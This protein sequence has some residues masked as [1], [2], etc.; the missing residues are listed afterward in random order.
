MSARPALSPAP[1]WG[2]DADPSRS[3]SSPIDW[4]W[5]LDP[6]QPFEALLEIGGALVRAPQRPVEEVETGGRILNLYL[7]VCALS[8]L[9]GEQLHEGFLDLT[10]IGFGGTTR[11]ILEAASRA[12]WAV[13]GRATSLR[14]WNLRRREWEL[15]ALSRT[16]AGAV[17]AGRRE[18]DAETAAA[19]ARLRAHRWTSSLRRRRLTIPARLRDLDLYPAD[20]ELLA[21]R[22]IEAG[23]SSDAPVLVAGLETAGT[24]YVAP[25]FAAALERLGYSH[26]EPLGLRP[27]C[28]L[29][30]ADARRLRR[31]AAAGCWVLVIDDPWQ[32][33]TF[34]RATTALSEVGVH[35]GRICLVEFRLPSGPCA[36]DVPQLPATEASVA[37]PGLDRARRA[38]LS[39]EEWHIHRLLDNDAVEHWLNRPAVLDRTGAEAAVVLASHRFRVDGQVPGA[40]GAPEAQRPSSRRSRVHKLFE[41]EL[42]RQGERWREL[43]LGRGVGLGFFG[44]HSRLIAACLGDRVP[45]VLGIDQGILFTRWEPGRGAPDPLEPEELDEIAAYVAARERRLGLGTTRGRPLADSPAIG[46]KH[47]GRLLSCSMGG[48]ARPVRQRVAQALSRA[49]APPRQCLA[50]GQMGPANWVRLEHGGLLKVGFQEHG[51]HS[52]EGYVADP[53]YD[54]AGASIGFRLEPE[55]ERRLLDRYVRLTGDDQDLPARLS[56]HKLLNALVDLEEIARLGLELRT[57]AGRSAYARELAIRETLVT[58]T[59]NEYLASLYLQDASTPYDGPPWVL[60]LEGV[61]ETDRLGFA[62]TSPAGVLALRALH[63]HGQQV[64]LTSG[65]SLG[66]VRERCRTYRLA[67]GIAED[68]A[69][70]WD[71]RR[72]QVLTLLPP[73]ARRDLARLR[74]ALS[75][76]TDSMTDPRYEHSIRL[77]HQTASG[78]RGVAADRVREWLS[79]LRAGDLAVIEE[80]RYTVIRPAGPDRMAALEGLRSTM[81]E[82]ARQAPLTMVGGPNADVRLL[83]GAGRRYLTGNAPPELRTLAGEV[84]VRQVRRPAQAGLLEVVGR[85]LHGRRRRCPACA[86]PR[87][88]RADAALLELLGV[89]DRSRPGQLA[90][91]IHPATLRALEI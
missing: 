45:D 9:L 42:H 82:T 80:H 41:V 21:A 90:F 49:V 13:H 5:C 40:S 37:R 26:V 73:E 6:H 14:M 58:R 20:C 78:R 83:G 50:D 2:S 18:P 68:G 48:T 8:Q 69:V 79:R 55:E 81:S 43:M 63:A 12:Q 24:Y 74:E 17:L 15:A 51:R 76:E 32:S 4:N 65:R 87:Q 61:L 59:V 53:A 91:L 54:L 84:E 1:P 3:A 31:L 28:P 34:A 11:R 72:E 46:A 56:V 19:V 35:Q 77:F 60:D 52:S 27:G 62:S 33:D 25:L 16:L 44:Y 85:V 30:P 39:P 7:V 70:A 29:L 71:A 22:A 23:L 88:G 47:L 38:S 36:G 86:L 64:L 66:E 89:Q 67:G 57:H 10:R 75:R